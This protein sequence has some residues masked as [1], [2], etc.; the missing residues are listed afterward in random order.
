MLTEIARLRDSY[1]TPDMLELLHAQI[2]IL[3]GQ[4][5]RAGL[6]L[7]DVKERVLARRLEDIDAYCCYL[8]VRSLYTEDEEDRE[9]LS[10]ILHLY[11][12]GGA[13]QSDGLLFADSHRHGVSG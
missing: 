5:D 3:A 7:A 2:C 4:R 11:Y 12:E 13:S 1:D 6:L 9:Q 8:Y 10:R